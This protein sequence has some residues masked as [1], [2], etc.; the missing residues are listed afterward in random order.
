MKFL[1]IRLSSMGDIILTQP[2]VAELRRRFPVAEIHFM[3]KPQY[4]SLAKMLDKDLSV[5]SYRKH[6]LW[7]WDLR[8]EK[9]DAVIDL[10]SK[11]SSFLVAC[12][13]RSIRKVFYN[14]QRALRQAI[15]AHKSD[16]VIRSTVELYASALE[17]LWDSQ[18]SLP[19]PRISSI[20]NTNILPLDPSGRPSIAIFPG[21]AHF[22]KMYPLGYWLDFVRAHPFYRF[23]LLGSPTE[24][25]LAKE[26]LQAT[27]NGVNLC[28]KLDWQA[29]VAIVDAC[30]LVIS[31]DSGPMHLAAALSKHQIAIFGSTHPSLGFAP[32]N[33]LA[34]ILQHDLPC[35]PC[36]L[37]GANNCPLGHFD[38]MVKTNPE[39][40]S[41]AC[42]SILSS[43]IS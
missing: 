29:L 25:N 4:A 18:V 34:V 11:L 1:I 42:R 3:T 36:S 40:L 39:M 8:R 27:D 28:G 31:G 19:P 16:A 23:V 15:V 17:K 35:R 9:F 5:L 37:H 38:C 12:C 33:D 2:V 20:N 41:E 26:I 43:T 13:A 10:H 21:A 7:H 14:K 30:D 22:T 24:N 32:A 6:P